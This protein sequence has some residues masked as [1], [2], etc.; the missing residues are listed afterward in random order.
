MEAPDLRVPEISQAELT[1]FNEAHFSQSAI[2]HF[3]TDFMRPYLERIPRVTS[4]ELHD[5]CYDDDDGL[6]YYE[7]GT[8]RTLTDE[9][10]AMFKH[11]ELEALRR[12]QERS[13][14]RHAARNTQLEAISAED[15]THAELTQLCS[16]DEPSTLSNAATSR[17]KRNRKHKNREHVEKPD[18]RKRTWDRVEPG[19]ATLD[20]D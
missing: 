5:E 10:I 16:E 13:T 4:H 1:F 11:S 3:D 20:Y 2:H 18:L 7:D 12:A 6:G 9:Q 8:K 17:K 14:P 15:A 19:L